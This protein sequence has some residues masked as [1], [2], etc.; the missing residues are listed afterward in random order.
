M[1]IPLVSSFSFYNGFESCTSY[2]SLRV[3]SEEI[4]NHVVHSGFDSSKK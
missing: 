1:Q 3:T 4:Y 2:C